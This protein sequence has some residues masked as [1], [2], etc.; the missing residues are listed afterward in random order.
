LDANR[1]PIR[2]YYKELVK[3]FTDTA[4]KERKRLSE[5]LSQ[6]ISS[7][8][9]VG[10]GV[11]TIL[12]AEARELASVLPRGLQAEVRVPIIV[13]K[14]SGSPYYRLLDCSSASI[15]MLRYLRKAGII[16]GSYADK[17]MLSQGDIISLVKKYKTLFIISII[18]EGHEGSQHEVEWEG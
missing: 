16:E 11:H 15:E 14:I 9:L 2:I 6:E 10:G 12:G 7:V 4:P 3:S 18:Y 8:E 13:A 1:D 17:C 5:V